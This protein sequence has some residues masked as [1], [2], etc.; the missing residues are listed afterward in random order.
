MKLESSHFVNAV[1]AIDSRHLT[2][3]SSASWNS[4]NLSSNFVIGH[5]LTIW[6]MVCCWP[7]SQIDD[8]AR[9]N[10]Y[11]FMWY[12]PW[13]VWKQLSRD[14]VWWVRSRPACQIVGSVTIVWLT[15]ETDDQS[16]LHCAVKICQLV[17]CLTILVVGKQ[18]EEV[19]VQRQSLDGLWWPEASCQLRNKKESNLGIH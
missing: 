6:F 9:P 5:M 17:S 2:A 4:C 15:T 1:V 12:G 13:P 18:G 7:Q 3:S 10:L 8:L 19:D 14:H 11:R 16:S